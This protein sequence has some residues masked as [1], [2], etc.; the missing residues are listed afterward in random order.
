MRSGGQESSVTCAVLQESV[1]GPLLIISYI[2]DVSKV[3][4]YYLCRTFKGVLMS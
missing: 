4:S 2:D 1:L 3:I